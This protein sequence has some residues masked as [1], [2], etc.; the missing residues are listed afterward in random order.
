V[1]SNLLWVTG[2]MMDFQLQTTRV[3]RATSKTPAFA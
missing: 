3:G 2:I 1:T